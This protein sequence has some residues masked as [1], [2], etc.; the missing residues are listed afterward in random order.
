MLYLAQL[1]HKNQD[2]V[3]KEAANKRKWVRQLSAPVTCTWI[4]CLRISKE[5]YMHPRPRKH[6]AILL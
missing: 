5:A 3:Q 2:K 1:L 6:L 4:M